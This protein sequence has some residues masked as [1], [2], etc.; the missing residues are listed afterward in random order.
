MTKLWTLLK[1]RL[2]C[3]SFSSLP[4][5][6]PEMK[7]QHYTIYPFTYCYVNEELLQRKAS[8][9]LLLLPYAFREKIYLSLYY[10]K[11]VF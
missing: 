6:E 2:L 5:S 7:I 9:L 3:D 11:L 1:K 8:L 10:C 4:Q